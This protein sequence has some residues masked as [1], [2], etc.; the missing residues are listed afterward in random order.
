M[1]EL[2]KA[3]TDKAKKKFFKEEKHI[4]GN[5]YKYVDGKLVKKENDEASRKSERTVR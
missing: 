4:L 1:L 3:A 2:I 5:H